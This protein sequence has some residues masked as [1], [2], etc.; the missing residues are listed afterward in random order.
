MTR[1]ANLFNASYRVMPMNILI[2]GA[3]R[4]IGLALARIYAERGD[5]VFACCRNPSQAEQLRELATTRPGKIVALD[6]RNDDSVAALAMSL[7]TPIDV[8]INNAGIIGHPGE[9][10]T[11]TSMDFDM[12]AEI[13]NVNTLGPVRVMQAMLPQLKRAAHAG[14]VA[15]V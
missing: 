12:W 14:S 3:N 13:F 7:S 4:G 8:L 2:T 6:V 1:V 10:Q 15:K 11:A 5:T 9:R